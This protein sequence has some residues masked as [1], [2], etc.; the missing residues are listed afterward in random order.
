MRKSLV[1]AMVLVLCCGMAAFAGVPDPSRSS[2]VDTGAST[3]CHYKFR[4]D[5]SGD[6]LTVNVTL[7]DAL[8][9]VVTGCSTTAQLVSNAGTLAFGDCCTQ[10][11]AGVTNAAGAV[12]FTFA[13]VSGRG[14][15]D[16]VV[17]ATC[18]GSIVIDTNSVE[19]TSTDLNAGATSPVGVTNVFDLGILGGSLGSATPLIAPHVY[20]NY[21]CDAAINVF[22]LGFFAGGLSVNCSN[23]TCP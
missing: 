4:A 11:Q 6:V 15:I 12:A 1:L 17:T 13:S 20:V 14:S 8:N 19:F 22:D 7:R 23:A 18:V 2:V 3:A 9:N 16:I 10:P 21:N 5:E